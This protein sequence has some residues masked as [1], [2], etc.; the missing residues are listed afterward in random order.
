MYQ[1]WD[2]EITITVGNGEDQRQFRGRRDLLTEHSG[3]FKS[4]LDSCTS[5]EIAVPSVSPEVFTRILKFV[6]TGLLDLTPDNIYSVLLATHLLH[7]PRALEICRSYLVLDRHRLLSTPPP[8]TIV[9]PIPSRKYFFWPPPPPF[10]PLPPPPPPPH[11]TTSLYVPPPPVHQP[12]E[13][14]PLPSTSI[15]PTPQEPPAPPCHEETSSTPEKLTKGVYKDIA[16]CDGPVR[17]KRVLNIN[18]GT[19]QPPETDGEKSKTEE[20]RRRIFICSFCKHTF[21][22]HYCFRKHTRRHLNPVSLNPM[23]SPEK[24]VKDMNVQ[25]Y[26]C[27]TCG[28]KFPS[29][30]FVH[31]HRKICHGNENYSEDKTSP[32]T[33]IQNE[34]KTNN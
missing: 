4:L 33:N 18:Y 1:G 26:P 15:V 3:Y 30:Y 8:P 24:E 29:Y 21:K 7:M 12:L 11:Y 17:F 19:V 13:L 23:R 22:S 6:N 16:C 32:S 9:K 20:A 28:S 25:Y 5:E 34:E 14:E 27:K 10:F 31:K 2:R